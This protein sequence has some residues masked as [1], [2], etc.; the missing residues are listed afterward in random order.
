[1]KPSQ[2]WKA[3]TPALEQRLTDLTATNEDGDDIG[4]GETFPGET[5]EID[6]EL[7]ARDRDDD[8]PNYSGH[9]DEYREPLDGMG[10]DRLAFEEGERS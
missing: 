4:P 1:M 3:S 10:A 8:F 2:I 5:Q 6:R 9:A 7:R